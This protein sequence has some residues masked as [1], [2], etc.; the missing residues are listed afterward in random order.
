MN[1]LLLTFHSTPYISAFIAALSAYNYHAHLQLYTD[2]GRLR[3]ILN[4]YLNNALKYTEKGSVTI[5]Y[6]L[7]G[8]HVRLWVRDTG[9]GIPAEYCNEHLFERFYKVDEFIAGTGLGL[10][11]C[12]SLAQTLGGTVGVQSKEGAG[13]LFWVEIALE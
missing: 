4:Q 7:R 13:S 6:E 3:E 10:S 2:R 1:N 9:K 11:I 8:E 5:G 12:R